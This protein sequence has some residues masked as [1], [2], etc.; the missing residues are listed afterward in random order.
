[1]KDDSL[2]LCKI[3]DLGVSLN[4]ME[5]IIKEKNSKLE[6]TE[7]YIKDEVVYIRTKQMEGKS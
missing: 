2:K 7:W 6:D 5:K 3:V 1:M 4:E